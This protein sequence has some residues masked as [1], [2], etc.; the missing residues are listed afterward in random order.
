MDLPP[1]LFEMILE[2]A[3]V[4]KSYKRK[5]RFRLGQLT[6]AQ[7]ILK[8]ARTFDLLFGIPQEATFKKYFSK[9]KLW[10]R[11]ESDERRY[12]TYI[13]EGTYH[14]SGFFHLKVKHIAFTSQ[15]QRIGFPPVYRNHAVKMQMIVLRCKALE[16]V[17]LYRDEVSE[18]VA[19]YFERMLNQVIDWVKKEVCYSDTPWHDPD[20]RWVK[21]K[22][23][24]ETARH[25][26][27][28][29]WGKPKLRAVA[30]TEDQSAGQGI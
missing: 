12:H 13:E 9:N 1:E 2:R 20:N 27:L 29:L 24:R 4:P 28:I 3:V 21:K 11:I 10:V 30:V 8:A 26:K 5:D 15:L 19:E 14:T 25:I 6:P 16:T 22:M 23:A 18:E 17:T 7:F